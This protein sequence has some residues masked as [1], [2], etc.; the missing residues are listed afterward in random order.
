MR[1][2]SP[3]P[4]V[5]HLRGKHAA[6]ARFKHPDDPAVLAARR[7]LRVETLA[8]HVERVVREAPPMTQ[9]QRERLAFLLF[10]DIE[11]NT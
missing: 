1:N 4:E 5:A 11:G 7:D 6:L 2:N 8:E 9:A 10:G 3:S